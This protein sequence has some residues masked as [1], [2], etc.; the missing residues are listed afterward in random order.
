MC[1]GPRV[2]VHE[3]LRE[4]GGPGAPECD[5]AGASRQ[6]LEDPEGPPHHL[7]VVP[8][9][10]APATFDEVRELRH[11]EAPPGRIPKGVH[12]LFDTHLN[13]TGLERHGEEEP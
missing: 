5:L 4:G 9:Q 8:R 10:R 2:R 11:L 13:A 3:T 6:P 1:A 12:L 7:L